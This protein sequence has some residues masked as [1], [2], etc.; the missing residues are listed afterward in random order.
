MLGSTILSKTVG[1]RIC[2]VLSLAL[3][4]LIGAYKL[5][6]S[7]LLPPACRFLPTCSDYAAEAI[8][9]HGALH[10]GRLAVCRLARCHPWGGSGFD[11]VP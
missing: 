8:M 2:P 1:T 6:V 7:P 11:P 5:F 4:L 3:R 9:R 10:G